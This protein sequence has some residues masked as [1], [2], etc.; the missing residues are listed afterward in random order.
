ME[1]SSLLREPN[2]SLVERENMRLNTVGEMLERFRRLAWH[3]LGQ[4]SMRPTVSARICLSGWAI[5]VYA[6]VGRDHEFRGETLE[7]AYRAAM[8]WAIRDETAET[9]ATLGLDSTGTRI[10]EPDAA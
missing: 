6:S 8:A 1:F 7:E 9:Y 3:K 5:T 2:T 4:P 10:V